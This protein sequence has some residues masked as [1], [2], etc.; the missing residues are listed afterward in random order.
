MRGSS[1]V[2]Q[3]TLLDDAIEAHGGGRRW[4][5]TE[6]I[7]AHVRSGGLLMR[8]KRKTPQFSDYGITVDTKRQRIVLDPYPEEGRRGVFDLG[9]V[10]IESPD[11]EMLEQREN[12]REMF[13]GTHGIARKLRWDYLDALYF[14]GYAMWNYLTI[15][16]VFEWPGIEISEGEALKEGDETWHRLDVSFPQSFHTHCPEQTFYFDSAGLLR[17]HDYFPE[18]VSSIANAVHLSERYHDFDGMRFATSRRVT[19]KGPLGSPLPAPT[20]VWIEL[21]DIRVE[22]GG[23]LPI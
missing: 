3:M 18:V 23:L 20:V 5:R 1:L 21:N 8:M 2:A 6:Q 4:R 7:Q 22:S 10:W 9:N 12:A 14:A 17:R 16:F 19:P 15:P 13:F 11:G